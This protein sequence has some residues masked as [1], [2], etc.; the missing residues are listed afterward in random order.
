MPGI[1]LIDKIQPKN[2]GFT[3]LVDAAQ[4]IGG[5]GNVLLAA[6]LPALTGDITTTVGTVATTLATIVTA[7]SAGSA[8]SVPVLTIDAKGRVTALSAAT[9]TIPESAVTNLVSDLAAKATDSLVVHLA[10]VETIT[11]KKTMSGGVTGLPTPTATTD[12]VTKAYADAAI[13]GLKAKPP[14][15]LVATSNISPLSGTTGTVDGKNIVGY[16]RILLTGQ[17][18]PTEN[19]I[20][21]IKSGSWTRPTDYF[22]VDATGS[23]VLVLGGNTYASTGWIVS[24]DGFFGGQV[25]VDDNPV[26]W[27]Q[28]TGTGRITVTDGTLVKSGANDLKRSAI[29]GDVSVPAGSNAATLTTTGVAAGTYSNA[30]VQVDAK[31]RVLTISQGAASAPSIPIVVAADTSFESP[32][33]YVTLIPHVMRVQGI[34]RI[35]G[36]AVVGR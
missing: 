12:A 30:T 24:N 15:G 20:W 2:N 10:G 29:T 9:I 8:T 13:L 21:E 25:I 19:G 23:Y 31:G 32:A 17:L 18:T 27:T 3:G 22:A 1:D 33:D 16:S 36:L 26:N 7:S 28:F 14:V 4:V 34:F 5:S 11:G 35:Q 6:T